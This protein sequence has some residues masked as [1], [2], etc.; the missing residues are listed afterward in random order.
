MIGRLKI[1]ILLVCL[2]AMPLLPQNISQEVVKSGIEAFYMADFE[3]AMRLLQSAIIND[4]LSDEEAFYA[5]LYVG[6]CHIR[7]NSDMGSAQL[8]FQRAIHIDPTEELDPTKIPPD[9]YNAFV[10]VKNAMLG[11]VIIISDPSDASV[12][13]INPST[14]DVKRGHTPQTFSNLPTN[15]YQ[16]LVSKNGYEIYSSS[17]D[18]QAGSADSVNVTLLETENSFF[19][20]YWPY[21]AGAIVASAAILAITSGGG[22]GDKPPASVTR[23]TLP[24]PPQ[25]PQTG[26]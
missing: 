15:V 6:F 25:R 21:G 5:H 26:N 18:V 19:L 24:G 12:V 4:I 7:H 8:Y 20:K 23:E 10:S 2:L 17:V 11:T 1:F 3:E 22:H 13:L 16:I 9:L 14:N